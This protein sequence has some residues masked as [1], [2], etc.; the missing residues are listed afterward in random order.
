MEGIERNDKQLRWN[1]Q[2]SLE[3]DGREAKLIQEKLNTT[4]GHERDNYYDLNIWKE[5]NEIT[6]KLFK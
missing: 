6:L 1:V 5:Y 3:K 2:E 4:S